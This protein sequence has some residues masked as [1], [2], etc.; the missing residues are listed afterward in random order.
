[1]SNWIKRVFSIG[2]FS[3]IT[4]LTIKTLRFYHDQRLIVPSWI[5]DQTGYRYYDSSKIEL[6]RVI[7][8]LRELEFSLSDIAEMLRQYDDE[9][10]LLD[11]L[12]RQRQFIDQR[13]RHYRRIGSTLDQILSQQREVRSTMQTTTLQVA[14]K[15][16][17]PQLV[18]AIRMKGKYCECGKAF[19]RIARRFGRYL[20]G[21]PLLLHYDCEY[22]EDDANFEACMPI[23]QGASA[24]GIEVRDLP[25]GKCVSLVHQGPYEDLGRSYAVILK[26]AHDHNYEIE[27]PTREVYLKG[28]GMIFKGN[29]K[30][31]LTEI[32]LMVK[33]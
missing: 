24:D 13:L 20:C 15:S 1:M 10:D 29:P 28:P 14:E 22:R 5:D 18:A 19:G 3:K 23:R 9:G 8:R 11:Y 4:G 7:V 16:L 17:G 2:E 32:Q 31:Y 27:I 25:G 12:E 30:K 21:P 33:S 26:Y 6:A